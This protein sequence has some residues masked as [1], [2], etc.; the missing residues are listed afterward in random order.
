MEE[1]A[2]TLRLLGG[3]AEEPDTSLLSVLS[4]V[5]VATL[6]FRTGAVTVT[7]RLE[8]GAVPCT[9]TREPAR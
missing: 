6:M 8:S 2:P 9:T 4:T 3:A 7:T 1:N 5:E